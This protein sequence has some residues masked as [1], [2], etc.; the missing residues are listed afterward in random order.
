MLTFKQIREEVHAYVAEMTAAGVIKANA[1]LLR[2]AKRQINSVIAELCA[3]FDYAWLHGEAVIPHHAIFDTGTV[4]VTAGNNIVTGTATSWTRDLKDQLFVLGDDEHRI[5]GINPATQVMTLWTPIC[6]TATGS[7]LSYE[8]HQDIYNIPHDGQK[9]HTMHQLHTPTHIRSMNPY[10]LVKGERLFQE[11]GETIRGVEYDNRTTEDS[12][13]A[14]GTIA[15]SDG[16]T[17][18]TGTGT[19]FTE[20]NDALDPNDTVLRID[21]DPTPY[22]IASITSATVL[23]LT[24]PFRN[25]GTNVT[26]KT[27]TIDRYRRQFRLI[28]R[29]NREGCVYLS[30]KKC[31]PELINDNDVPWPMPEEYHFAVIVQGAIAKA[32]KLRDMI[33]AP[34]QEDFGKAVAAMKVNSSVDESSEAIRIRRFGEGGRSNRFIGNIHPSQ[35]ISVP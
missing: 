11:S 10:A 13:Y 9:I 14:V 12:I 3:E 8:I 27:Y 17:T 24:F 5:K 32:L 34:V 6:E 16:S 29:P 7:T 2:T 22:T 30:Y 31:I 15:V 18:V 1:S 21:D 25:D 23:E 33:F 26:L 19:D 4:A 28:Q 20:L 35:S